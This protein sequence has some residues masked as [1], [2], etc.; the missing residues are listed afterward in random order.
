M[1]I[2]IS[3]EDLQK[4]LDYCAGYPEAQVI[5]Q[6][7]IRQCSELDPWLPIESAPKDRPVIIFFRG[8]VNFQAVSEYNYAT[9]IFSYEYFTN[10]TPTH[11]RELTADPKE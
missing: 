4:E 8:N 9:N 1:T 2:G 11:W 10:S 5:I 3:K 7:L 6:A